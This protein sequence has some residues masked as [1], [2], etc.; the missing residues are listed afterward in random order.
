VVTCYA[1][2]KMCLRHSWNLALAGMA[3]SITLVAQQQLGKIEFEVVSIKPADPN[4]PGHVV[5]QS[6]G[7]FRGQNL[8]LFELIMSAWHL[9]RDQLIGGPNWLETAGW[10]ID[11]RLPAGANPAELPQMMQSMLADR[12]RLATHREIRALAVYALTVVKSG[13]KLHLGDGR[14]GM[15]AGPRLIRYGSGTM[16]E[17]AGQLSSYLHREV[18]DRTGITGQYAINLSFAPVDL[19]AS[20]GDGVQDSA[21]SIFQ[22]LQDQAGLKLE[23]AKGPVEVLIIDHA[24][25]PMPD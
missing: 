6:P 8:R 13:I 19:N 24:E 22:A 4:A 15:S 11:A 25:R 17:L 1:N 16:G 7:R 21:P 2:P 12:F 20:V 23:S 9:N 3:V 5:Q 14:G 18:I 10:D